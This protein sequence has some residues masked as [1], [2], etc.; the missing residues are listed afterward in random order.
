MISVPSCFL[1]LTPLLAFEFQLLHHATLIHKHHALIRWLQT[2]GNQPAEL[3]GGNKN[4][5]KKS[6]NMITGNRIN[7]IRAAY[8]NKK[9]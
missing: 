3:T 8:L 4:E 5:Q 1:N 7:Y 2:T 9:P 6:K